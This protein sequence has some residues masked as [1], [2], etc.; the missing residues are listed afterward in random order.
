MATRAMLLERRRIKPGRTLW[1]E[2]L[3]CEV[4]PYTS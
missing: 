1:E 3:E 2:F 4:S